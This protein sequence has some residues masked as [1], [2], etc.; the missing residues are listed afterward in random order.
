MS[1]YT[2]AVMGTAPFGSL[3]AGSM[4]SL[5]SAPGTLIFGGIAC[6]IG[7][8]LFAKRLPYFIKSVT[9]VYAK[10]GITNNSSERSTN[11]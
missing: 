4:A 3:M 9:P 11:N 8:I 1:F 6:T 2:M 5:I 7:A 10:L